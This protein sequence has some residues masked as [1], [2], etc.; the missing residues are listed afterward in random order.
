MFSIRDSPPLLAL[1]PAVLLS[2]AFFAPFELTAQRRPALLQPMELDEAARARMGAAVRS[3]REAKAA[4]RAAF[5]KRDVPLPV[6]RLT[7]QSDVTYASSYVDTDPIV[8]FSFPDETHDFCKA[9]FDPS[10]ERDYTMRASLVAGQAITVT[11]TW[12]SDDGT[13]TDFDL[14]LFDRNGR[15]AGDPTGLLPDG[16]SS[17]ASQLTGAPAVETA[18]VTAPGTD[19]PVFAVVDR[20]RGTGASTL[21]MTFTGEDGAFTVDEY[22]GAESLAH[23]DAVADTVVAPLTD[24]AVLD[25]DAFGSPRPNFNAAFLTDGCAQSASFLLIDTISGDTLTVSLDDLRP[26]ALFGDDAGDYAASDLPAGSYRLEV[27]PYAGPGG[28]GAAGNPVAASFTVIGTPADPSVAGFTLIDADT[29]SPI[30]G[31][32]P[33]ADG[34]VLDLTELPENLNVRANVVDPSGLVGSVVLALARSDGGAIGEVVATD[35]AVPFSLL[36]DAAGDFA[37][38]TFELGAY[39]LSGTPYAGAGASG[40]VYTAAS[41]ALTVIGPRIESYTLIDADSETPVPGFDPIAEG[42]VLDLSTLPPNLNVRANTRDPRVVLESVK[43]TLTQEG[44]TIRSSTERARPYSLFGDF[45]LELQGTDTSIDVD[46]PNIPNYGVWSLPANGAYVLLGV[47]FDHNT[48]SAGKAYGPLTLN[49]SLV[50]APAG[51]AGAATLLVNYPNPFNPETTIRFHLAD[52]DRVTLRVFDAVGREVEVL[53]DGPV[54][55]GFHYVLFDAGRLASGLYFYR[56]DTG[57]GTRYRSMLL[58][59]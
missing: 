14:Y 25:L 30:A 5:G 12:S 44:T 16:S 54:E 26:F 23:I 42:A 50:N 7:A 24:G 17:Q 32:D 36:G 9:E 1:M 57:A 35:D 43:F 45:N 21:S 51:V 4:G 56:L 28:T 46:P 6:L 3:L 59:K 11:L 55:A 31:F 20:F 33:I 27:I 18:F 48:P 41:I 22:V 13:V 39:T 34:A 19:E 40:E 58:A 53:L 37:A 49:F 47:P 38:G 8:A 15:L 52:A 10:A 29:D 2:Y